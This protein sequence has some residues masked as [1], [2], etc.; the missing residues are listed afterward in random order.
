[1]KLATAEMLS[2]NEN[3]FENKPV[4]RNERQHIK[5]V[6]FCNI[7]Y[8]FLEILPIKLAAMSLTGKLWSGWER[9][10]SFRWY[11]I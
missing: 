11:Y 9:T 8:S 1:L 3:S 4:Q 10:G 6:S 7:T 5:Q 2:K